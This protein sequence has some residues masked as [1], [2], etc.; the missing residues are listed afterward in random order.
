[1]GVWKELSPKGKG[2]VKGVEVS[3]LDKNVFLFSFNHE[4]NVRRVWDRRPWM[5]KG[6]HLILK[7]F[8]QSLIKHFICDSI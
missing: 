5:F 4:A 8:I 3:I 2:Q 1:M 7:E 6:D